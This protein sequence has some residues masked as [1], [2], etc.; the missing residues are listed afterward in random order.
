[1][2]KE[3]E[4]KLYR[5]VAVF[6]GVLG[7]LCHFLPPQYQAACHFIGNVCSGNIGGL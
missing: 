5:R 4:R 1:V 6:G 3:Q 7:M 2:T